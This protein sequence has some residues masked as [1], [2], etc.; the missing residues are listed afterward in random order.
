MPLEPGFLFTGKALQ[1][2]KRTQGERDVSR[3]V[4]N[5][6]SEKASSPKT[7]QLGT[8]RRNAFSS[9]ENRGTDSGHGG[10]RYCSWL[11]VLGPILAVN[12]GRT[13]KVQPC[14]RDRHCFLLSPTLDRFSSAV[15]GAS[16][17]GFLS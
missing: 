5:R 7:T 3:E 15:A 9:R 1:I 10:S 11:I 12:A 6:G 14:V 8:Y 17:V 4:R 13:S 16:V 2:A